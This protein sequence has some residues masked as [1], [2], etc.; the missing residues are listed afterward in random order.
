MPVL[1]TDPRDRAVLDAALESRR[2]VVCLCAAW[3]DTC[4]EFK[5]TFARLADADPQSAYVWIDIEDDSELVGDLDIEN[6]PTLAVFRGGTPLF[7]GVTLPQEAVV[8]RTLAA[9]RADAP[10]QK[11]IP[12]AIAVLPRALKSRQPGR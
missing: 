5:G 1:S 8:A 3:C 4:E 12:E 7:Y 9:V 10:V 11:N 2:V 6:F